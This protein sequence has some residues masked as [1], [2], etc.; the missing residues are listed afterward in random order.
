MAIKRIKIEKKTIFRRFSGRNML[1]VKIIVH[2]KL[3]RFQ[4]Q[5]SVISANPDVVR[6][7][8]RNKISRQL[9]QETKKK[10]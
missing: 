4:S 2:R 6:I 7:S 3:C 1:R 9:T 5:S 8:I 10:H